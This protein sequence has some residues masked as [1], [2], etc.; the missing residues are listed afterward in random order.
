MFVVTVVFSLNHWLKDNTAVVDV[1]TVWVVGS[2]VN[3]VR[4]NAAVAEVLN[5]DDDRA[6]G[7]QNLNELTFD[8]NVNSLKLTNF[9]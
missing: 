1:A 8:L 3:V 9:E 6:L 5:K 7:P 2:T 4:G